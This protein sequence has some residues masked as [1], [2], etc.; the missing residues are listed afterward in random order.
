MA[1]QQGSQ[2]HQVVGRAGEREQGRRLGLAAVAQLAQAADGL[3]PA[4]GLLDELAPPL[5]D[6]VAPVPW[7]APIEGAGEALA[8]TCGV[9]PTLPQTTPRQQVDRSSWLHVGQ[10]VPKILLLI[11]EIAEM[12]K[13]SLASLGNLQFLSDVRT[14][15]G[16]RVGSNEQMLRDFTGSLAATNQMYDFKFS[17]CEKLGSFKLLSELASKRPRDFLKRLSKGFKLTSF[18]SASQRMNQALK[19]WHDQHSHILVHVALQLR[20]VTLPLLKQDAKRGTTVFESALHL[21]FFSN[22]ANPTN[23][24]LSKSTL[25]IQDNATVYHNDIR[26]VSMNHAILID[27]LASLIYAFLILLTDSFDIILVHKTQPILNC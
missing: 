1:P 16:N 9:T 19:W 22:V 13:K 21:S 26:S 20:L 15:I 10:P 11:I 25:I 2:A 24:L 7:R 4:V 12:S 3:H 8:A 17:W 5:A 27:I 6:G 18:W 23:H 14:V